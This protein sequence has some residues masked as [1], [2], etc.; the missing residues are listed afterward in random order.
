ML[1]IH[2]TVSIDFSDWLSLGVVFHC[3]NAA[4]ILKAGAL[5]KLRGMA[6]D[7]DSEGTVI[8]FG[9]TAWLWN[10][11]AGTLHWVRAAR[12]GRAMRLSGPGR[13]SEVE[14]QGRLGRGASDTGRRSCSGV[15]G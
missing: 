14:K 3:K 8:W 11:V 7:L 1:T 4:I 12:P 9:V 13:K 2:L 10:L 6:F 5:D 15:D